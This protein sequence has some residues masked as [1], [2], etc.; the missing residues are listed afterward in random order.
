MLDH[1]GFAVPPSKF[2]QVVAWYVEALA[3][4]GCAKQMEFPGQAVGFGPS[5]AEAPFWIAAKEDAN[6]TGV[7]V[8]FS[9]KDHATVDKWYEAAIKAGGKDNGKPGIR[10]MYHPSYYG[11]FVIDPVG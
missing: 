3:P 5:K 6:P 9:A 8:A 11:A 7:H 4:L 10:E 2:D 1:F